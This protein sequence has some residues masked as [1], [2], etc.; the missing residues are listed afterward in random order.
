MFYRVTYIVERR[1]ILNDS[2]V[3]VTINMDTQK[4]EV[5]EFI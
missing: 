4:S 3:L 1:P 5:V 2:C